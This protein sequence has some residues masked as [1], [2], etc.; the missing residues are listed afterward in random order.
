MFNGRMDRAIGGV[1]REAIEKVLAEHGFTGA[2]T[3]RVE[4]ADPG[5]D[6]IITFNDAKEQ[7]RYELVGGDNKFQFLFVQAYLDLLR[8][9][10]PGMDIKVVR[11]PQ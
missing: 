7:F 3:L 10:M 2:F 8:E 1:Y 9:R 5:E 6:P 4:F 11:P